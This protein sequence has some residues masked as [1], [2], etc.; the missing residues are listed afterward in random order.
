MRHGSII[1]EIGYRLRPVLFITALLS[2]QSFATNGQFTNSARVNELIHQM[3]LRQKVGQLLIFG[4]AG[5]SADESLQRLVQEQQPGALI[6]F[7]RNIQTL[8]Q[9]AVLNHQ[10]QIWAKSKSKVPLLIMVDQEGGNVARLKVRRSLPS[11]L[12][13]GETKDLALIQQYGEALGQMMRDLGFNVNL[14]PV[15]D[16]SDPNSIS[17]IGPRSFGGQPNDVGQSAFAFAKG[18]ATGG[19]IPTAKHFPGHGGIV[20]DSHRETPKKLATLEELI[21]GDLV[22]FQK[23]ANADFPRAVMMAHISYPQIDPSGT[24]AAFSPLFIHQVLRQKLRYDGL[25]ITDD[26]EMSG[27]NAAGPIEDRVVRAIEAGNDMVMV[28]WSVRRQLKAADAL[29][30]AVRSGRITE[31]RINQSLERILTYKLQLDSQ[32][33][34]G[35]R[36]ADDETRLELL[37]E[38]VKRFNFLKTASGNKQLRGSQINRSALTIFASDPR[39]F[40]GFKQ[41]YGQ[42]VNFIRL[43]QQSQ[44]SLQE[45]LLSH[46]QQTFVY[47]ASG[48]Q[49]ARWL[50]QLTGDVKKRIIVVNTNQA[51][52]IDNRQSYSGVFQ[53]NT[54]APESGAWLAQFLTDPTADLKPFRI[55]EK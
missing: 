18:L 12:A 51:G 37:A 25:I 26:V 35:F 47:Y 31:T 8:P 54:S 29:M 16:L 30:S 11:A 55:G 23:F 49:T 14:A 17:F 38:K 32:N 33:K 45:Q 28:A 39:F 15:E 48:A 10:A 2:C 19:V 41:R 3:S 43:T 42:N 6:T 20:Q 4:Y 13:L 53:L 27:A 52:A 21:E 34:H 22:P 7:G 36:L 1:L 40:S 46:P 44:E 50:N 9:I 5:T 24:P